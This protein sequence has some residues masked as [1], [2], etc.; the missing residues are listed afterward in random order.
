MTETFA[1]T[2]AT[3]T[4][5]EITL[6]LQTLSGDDRPVFVAGNF[7]NWQAADEN[8]RLQSIGS[9][10][11][12]LSFVLPAGLSAHLM[13]YKYVRGSWETAE[14]DE[15]GNA[16]SNRQ[17][18]FRS[19]VAKD[20]VPRWNNSGVFYQASFLPQIRILSENFE[21]PQLIRTRRVSVLLPYNYDQTDKSYPV[22]YLQ[23]GQNLFDDYAPFGSWG[24]DKRLALLA[25][26]G[27]GDVII[28]AIDH[29]ED[30][31]IAEF[32][33]SFRTRLGRGDGKQYVRFLAETLKPYID[34]NFRT[35]PQSSTTG[36]GG[37]SMG[38][39]ISIY[40]GLMY[41][42]V[43]GR[44]MIFSPSLWV[45]PN[46][47]FH[48]LNLNQPYQGRIYLYGGGEEGATM[49]PNLKRFKAELERRGGNVQVDFEL[50]FDPKGRHN[51]ARWGQEFPRAVEWLFF[52]EVVSNNN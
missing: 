11:F 3:A 42:Q 41:P 18:P 52:Q 24:V 19:K 13:E 7:N 9:G 4:N 16:T 10:K 25:E 32:T 44:L 50:S 5:D 14:L 49:L 23:D 34:Q 1:A 27:N 28:V 26:R 36:I 17:L 43:Y 8:Y 40:A 51:E 6:E 29:A 22:L 45:S 48:A 2:P 46:I 15:Y 35:L 20:K 39:L 21:I 31:R 37:S 38:G 33:P 30:Q 12:R 47:P